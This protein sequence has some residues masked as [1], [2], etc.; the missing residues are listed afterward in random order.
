[1]RRS[2]DQFAIAGVPKAQIELCESL[3]ATIRS[4]F[5]QRGTAW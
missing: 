3:I 4:P 5:E 2:R 1:M